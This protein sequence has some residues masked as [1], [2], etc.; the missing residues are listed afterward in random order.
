MRN[1]DMYFANLSECPNCKSNW[2]GESIVEK[3]KEIRDTSKV[4]TRFTDMSDEDIQK[5]V[6]DYYSPP[7]TFKREIGIEIQGKYD[8]VSYIKCPDCNAMFDRFTGEKVQTEI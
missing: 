4:K 2:V 3:F 5:Y 7:Y 1:Y 8:G 6:E